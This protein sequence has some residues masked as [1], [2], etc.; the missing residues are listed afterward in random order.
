MNPESRAGPAGHCV[1]PGIHK[2]DPSHNQIPYQLCATTTMESGVIESLAA[3]TQAEISA[4]GP[5]EGENES[6]SDIESDSHGNQTLHSDFPESSRHSNIPESTR[7]TSTSDTL[8]DNVK[9]IPKSKKHWNIYLDVP[10]ETHDGTKYEWEERFRH[11]KRRLEDQAKNLRLDSNP[12]YDL[13]MVGSNREDARPTIVVNCR[14]ADRMSLRKKFEKVSTTLNIELEPERGL[15]GFIHGISNM[16]RTEEPESRTIHK[17]RLRV[18]YYGMTA[19]QHTVI[20]MALSGPLQTSISDD[21]LTCGAITQYGGAYATL[22]VALHLGIGSSSPVLMTVNHLFPCQAPTSPSPLGGAY[23][24]AFDSDTSSYLRRSDRHIDTN[25]PWN[26]DDDEDDCGDDYEDEYEDDFEDSYE[27]STD[28]ERSLQFDRSSP[29][30]VP[31]RA[32]PEVV[33]NSSLMTSR[34]SR[35]DQT[36]DS[37]LWELVEPDSPLDAQYAY[38][39]WALIRPTLSQN[40]PTTYSHNTFFPQGRTMGEA[41]V[42]QD[43]EISPLNHLAPVYMISGMRGVKYGQIITAPSFI[44]SVLP[45][46]E[47]CGVWTVILDERESE[48]PLETSFHPIISGRLMVL[49]RT[50][51]T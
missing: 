30:D 24:P 6:G 9:A 21:G 42:I 12:I 32:R 4:Q 28:T 49:D 47:S 27:D 5:D 3:T 34:A 18:A 26:E 51:L 19:K 22:G 35:L 10:V 14:E 41:V 39:D 20:R 1:V 8:W 15:M 43:L 45:Q 23:S 25:P 50:K 11:V 44:P 29:V 17:A 38:L 48:L 33:G 7:P 36:A 13:R 46:Q 37:E 40:N 16:H 31:T 2:K